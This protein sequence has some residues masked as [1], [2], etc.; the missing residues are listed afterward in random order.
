LCQNLSSLALNVLVVLE[1]YQVSWNNVGQHSLLQNHSLWRVGHEDRV[2]AYFEDAEVSEEVTK[3]KRRGVTLHYTMRRRF[4]RQTPRSGCYSGMRVLREEPS[5][6]QP[7]IATPQ[8]AVCRSNPSC[9]LQMG[10]TTNSSLLAKKQRKIDSRINAII[11]A[12]R[13]NTFNTVTVLSKL[14]HCRHSLPV[15]NL[16]R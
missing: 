6:P 14:G 5:I 3:E 8:L 4:T 16:I 11:Q 12:V 13:Q 2:S 15:T 7:W 10:R 9:T 1:D